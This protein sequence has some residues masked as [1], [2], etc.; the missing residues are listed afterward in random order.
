MVS[1]SGT[2][3]DHGITF[4]C[5]FLAGMLKRPGICSARLGPIDVVIRDSVVSIVVR[6]C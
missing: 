1:I 5:G 6:G 4:A 2:Q 3:D